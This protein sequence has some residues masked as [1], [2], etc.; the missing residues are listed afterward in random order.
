MNFSLSL[1]MYWI[2][3]SS[4]IPVFGIFI[5]FWASHHMVSRITNPQIWNSRFDIYN[6]WKHK[7]SSSIFTK[8]WKILLWS[9]DLISDLNAIVDDKI[10]RVLDQFIIR[11]FSAIAIIWLTKMS[12]SRVSTKHLNSSF[13]QPEKYFC[14]NHKENYRNIIRLEISRIWDMEAD[15]IYWWSFWTSMEAL[16]GQTP[17]SDRTLW[18]CGMDQTLS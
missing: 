15:L 1:S 13:P 4:N 16:R 10:T 12:W 8:V 6:S 18:H 5:T 3:L 14:W 11:P 7:V 17:Y 9:L 2:N